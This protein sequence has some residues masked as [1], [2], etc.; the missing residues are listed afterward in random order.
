MYCRSLNN[1]SWITFKDKLH[2]SAYGD[3]FQFM[4]NILGVRNSF[5][6][7]PTYIPQKISTIFYTMTL[8]Y[9]VRAHRYTY[10]VIV[11]VLVWIVWIH[12]VWWICVCPASYLSC[13][14]ICLYTR[15]SKLV[16]LCE[17]LSHYCSNRFPDD[18]ISKWNSKYKTG[19]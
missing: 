6:V 15:V 2:K 11:N 8:N 9:I 7:T 5:W 17:T 19:R 18:H 4:S 1:V 14:H 10:I 13:W 12:I 16:R 3:S